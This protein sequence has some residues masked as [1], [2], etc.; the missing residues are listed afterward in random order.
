[1]PVILL[2]RHAQA[3]YGAADYD[4]LSGRAVEQ[5]LALRRRLTAQGIDPSRLVGVTGPRRRQRDTAAQVLP[6]VRMDVDER[7][8]EYSMDAVLE[9][10]GDEGNSF[11]Q[12]SVSITSRQMQVLLDQALARWTGDESGSW[13]TFSTAVNSAL[14]SLAAR[15]PRGGMGVA[16]TSAGPIAS[17]TATVLGAASAFVPLNRVQVNTGVTKLIVGRQ[18]MSIVTFNDHSHLENLDPSLLT[19]R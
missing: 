1:M 16:F 9:T 4:A 7:W 17:A 15:V 18:G 14:S 19:Y 11:S 10:H 3:S 2:V 5:S 8:D 12:L 6:G 13:A